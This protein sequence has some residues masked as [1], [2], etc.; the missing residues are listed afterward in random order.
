MPTR[1]NA[2]QRG[3]DKFEGSPTKLAAAIG[4][5]VLRQHVEHWVKSE[6][7]PERVGARFAAVTGVPLWELYPHD[8]HRIFPMVVGTKG[9]PKP[10]ADSSDKGSNSGRDR[11]HA[12]AAGA[13]PLE[14]AADRRREIIGRDRRDGRKPARAADS[15][16]SNRKGG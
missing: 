7:V 12:K 1:S 15:N 2:V 14:K 13:A 11:D 9:A 6:R 4:E 16:P 10:P 5:G 3:L 8:W